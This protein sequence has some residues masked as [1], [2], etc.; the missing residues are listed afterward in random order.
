M[1]TAGNRLRVAAC[2]QNQGVGLGSNTVSDLWTILA[3]VMDRDTTESLDTEELRA[4]IDSLR[5]GVQVV[6]PAWRYL[7][8]N[9]A[10]VRHG[11]RTRDEL[12]GRT[13]MECYPGIEDTE[14]FA[15]LERCMREGTAA[16]MEN[17]F[18]Y[19]DGQQAWFEL[20][21]QPCPAGIIVLSLDITKRKE[22]AAKLERTGRLHALGRMSAGVVHDLRN[23]LNPL[24]LNLTR[25]E[26]MMRDNA[27]ATNVIKQIRGVLASGE[28]LISLLRDFSR[29]APATPATPIDPLPLV[30]EAIKLA[31]TSSHGSHEIRLVSELDA[32]PQV[33][34]T[35]SE[36]LSCV[37]NLIINALDAI[38]DTA[39]TI[40]VRSRADDDGVSIEVEDDGPGMPAGVIA[41]AFE[42]FFTTKG[43]AGTG[44]GLSSVYGFARRSGGDAT[45]RSTVGEGTLVRV[46][47]PAATD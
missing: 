44:L 5:E 34:T 10:V 36:L 28:E 21:V 7:Y 24:G 1:P 31:R 32:V 9:D 13:M 23:L 8:V 41:R 6:S 25:L 27:R 33:C 4:A 17:K 45:I 43:D 19:P 22:L 20:R 47:L 46:S 40:I 29:E 15:T 38:G 16:E 26:R 30:Q 3:A 18:T 12:V 35:G 37:V 11:R 39:G 42:P 2:L 14:M